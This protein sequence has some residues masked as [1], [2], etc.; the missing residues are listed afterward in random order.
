MTTPSDVYGREDHAYQRAWGLARE[1]RGS[2]AEVRQATLQWQ[3]EH[4]METMLIGA[5]TRAKTRGLPF[6]ITVDDIAAVYP[7]DGL[8]YICGV[9]M[10]RNLG[11]KGPAATSPVIDR[12]RN[13]AGYVRGNVHVICM[14]DNS[15]KQNHTL[16][17]LAGP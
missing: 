17:E 7:V 10:A 16:A 6:G 14:R 1:R 3:H 12:I 15:V 13:E 5:K 2:A 8:C 11:G 4:P 9:T